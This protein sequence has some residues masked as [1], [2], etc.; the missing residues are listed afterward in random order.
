MYLE[1]ME[2][3]PPAATRVIDLPFR[4][5]TQAGRERQFSE[6]YR[7]TSYITKS[8]QLYIYNVLF[9]QLAMGLCQYVIGI[10]TTRIQW[11]EKW[12]SVIHFLIGKDI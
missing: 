1:N 4:A 8:Q 5:S 12:R 2:K 7:A 6:K 9:R 10:S 11:F 3:P